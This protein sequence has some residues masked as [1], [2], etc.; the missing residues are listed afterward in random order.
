[1]ALFL[2]ISSVVHLYSLAF[3]KTAKYSYRG[4]IDKYQELIS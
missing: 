1:M 4:I 2:E 3:Q